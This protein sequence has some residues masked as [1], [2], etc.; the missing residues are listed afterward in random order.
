MKDYYDI[1]NRR[2]PIEEIGDAFR[3][4]ADAIKPMNIGQ[5]REQALMRGLGAGINMGARAADE[6]KIRELESYSKQLAEQDMQLKLTAGKNQ[7]IKA[8]NENFF[9]TN[10]NDLATLNNFLAKGDFEA[11]NIM[12]PTLIEN[13]KKITGNEI[14]E[15]AYSRDGKVYLDNGKGEVRGMYL[16]D[17][18]QGIIPQ[19]E[20]INFPE[21]LTY[22]SKSAVQNKM[23]EMRLKNEQI[24]AQIE[25]LKAHGDLYKSQNSPEVIQAE[26]NYKNAQANKLNQEA[27]N[28]GKEFNKD[29]RKSNIEFL[30]EAHNDIKSKEKQLGAYTN[31]GNLIT[32]EFQTTWNRSGAGLISKAQRFLNPS[33]TDAARRQAQIEMEKEPLYHEIRKIFTG[34]V[35][36]KDVALFVT[37]LPDLNNSYEANM[38]II[39]KRKNALEEDIFKLKTTRDLIQNSDYSTHFTHTSIQDKVDQMNKERLDK[40]EKE[41]LKTSGKIKIDYFGKILDINKDELPNF[42]G[43]IV[44][45]E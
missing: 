1:L 9:L 24:R 27:L 30:E 31:I 44:L 13:Y 41:K 8:E 18:F 36:D 33:F 15:Y 10:R 29:F 2:K 22:N 11:I 43:A 32:E 4:Q 5:R 39:N 7:Q 17:I 12:S 19:E 25:N 37:T 14:G 28:V 16:A 20:Q 23:E 35:S 21:L 42:K 40:I 3:G 38:D 34:A 45:N 26:I 6:A